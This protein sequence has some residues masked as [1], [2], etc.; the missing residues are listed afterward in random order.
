LIG[1]LLIQVSRT[2]RKSA[3]GRDIE[4]LSRNQMAFH[5]PF[6]K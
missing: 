4:K 3:I 1:S 2:G 6:A 5:W